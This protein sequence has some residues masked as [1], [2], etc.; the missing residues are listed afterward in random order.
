M[1]AP[2]PTTNLDP[3][4]FPYM[5]LEQFPSCLVLLKDLSPQVSVTDRITGEL[6][7]TLEPMSVAPLLTQPHF[8]SLTK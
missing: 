3:G 7:R 4:H 8:L 5:P 2:L 1:H 6:S